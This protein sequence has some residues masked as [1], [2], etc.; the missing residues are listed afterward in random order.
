M[1]AMVAIKLDLVAPLHKSLEAMV[2]IVLV[3]VMEILEVLE[4]D[5]LVIEGMPI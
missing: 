5:I 1:L 2:N 4:K 3:M